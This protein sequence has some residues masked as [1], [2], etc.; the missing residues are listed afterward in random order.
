MEELQI[1]PSEVRARV[2]DEHVQIR[3]ML[4]E[5]ESLAGR[6]L[7]GDAHGGAQLRVKMIELHA[8]L[9]AHMSME[10]ALLYPAI[11]DA[12]AWGELRGERMKEEHRRQ[13]AVLSQLADR[14]RGD[15]ATLVDALRSLARD[16]REDMCKEERELLHPELLRDDV[17][18][19]AQNSG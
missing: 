17:I 19:I 5:L 14:E 15:T 11:C 12:D 4:V 1:K 7:D 10:D 6:A 13:R 16:I 8:V 9:D 18:S 2:L 3:A